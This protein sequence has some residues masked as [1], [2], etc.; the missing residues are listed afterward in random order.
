M[1]AQSLE[2]KITDASVDEILKILKETQ[3]QLR[4]RISEITM[5][6]EVSQNLAQAMDQQKLAEFIVDSAMRYLPS[7]SASLLTFESENELTIRASRGLASEVVRKTRVRLGEGIAGWVAKHGEPLLL[8]GQ[9]RDKRFQPLAEKEGVKSAICL[10]LK[11]E[12]RVVGVLNMTNL[13]EQG[14]FTQDNLR[15]LMIIGDISAIA[16]ENARLYQEMEQGCFST[17][18]AL[19]AAI[20]AKDPCTRGHCQAVSNYAL[21]IADELGF[22]KQEKVHI[23]SAALLHDIGK[24]GIPE[25]ILKKP[26]KLT[27]KEQNVVKLHPYVGVQILEPIDILEP[28]I[29][30]IYYHHERFDGKG[31]LEGLR[32]EQIPLGARVLAVADAFDAMTSDRPYRR[33]LTIAEAAEELSRCSGS[34]FDPSIVKAFLKVIK[35]VTLPIKA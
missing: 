17:I 30:I 35:K 13:R 32:G 34:Q 33:A 4:A 14:I 3:Q 20:D 18:A 12:G 29:S 26:G 7:D 23:E 31:Y 21:A 15:V 2:G 25:K 24:I 8:F 10:P 9:V 22:S 1:V 28:I 5:L 27:L 19:A 16:M 11:Y 6:L